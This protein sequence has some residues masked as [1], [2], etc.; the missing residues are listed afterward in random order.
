ML[1]TPISVGAFLTNCYIVQD[2]DSCFLIDAPS[3]GEEI[4][5][6]LKQIQVV[7]DLVILTHGHFDHVLVLRALKEE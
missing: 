4:I 7:P 2:S 6:K 3:P 1:I 5:N